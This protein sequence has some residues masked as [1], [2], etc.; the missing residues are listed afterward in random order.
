MSLSWAMWAAQGCT[1][2]SKLWT[3]TPMQATTSSTR[4]SPEQQRSGSS[5]M[6]RQSLQKLQKV[7]RCAQL[8]LTS[9]NGAA[10]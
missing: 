6:E 1:P 3:W 4:M 8:Q 7:G 10:Q 9:S 5:L 2:P